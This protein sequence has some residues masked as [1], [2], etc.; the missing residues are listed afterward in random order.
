MCLLLA[1]GG[2]SYSPKT[3]RVAKVGSSLR[4]ET[5]HGDQKASVDGTLQGEGG[6]GEVCPKHV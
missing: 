5:K 6:C 3:G 4:K 1:A 2:V